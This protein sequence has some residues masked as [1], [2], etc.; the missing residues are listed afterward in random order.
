MM[1]M[2]TNQG[3]K[4]GSEWARQGTSPHTMNETSNEAVVS[5][6]QLQLRLH[7]RWARDVGIGKEKHDQGDMGNMISVKG[8][9][10]QLMISRPRRCESS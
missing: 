8:I 4:Q 5:S 6:S 2:S 7:L 9:G 10:Y 1:V 3:G